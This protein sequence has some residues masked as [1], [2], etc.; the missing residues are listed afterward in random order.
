[1]QIYL[2]DG[3]FFHHSTSSVRALKGPSVF[4]LAASYFAI[5][6]LDSI[7]F[8]FSYKPVHLDMI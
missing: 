7:L 2:H 5:Y 8:N 4:C 6:V 3:C 1:M